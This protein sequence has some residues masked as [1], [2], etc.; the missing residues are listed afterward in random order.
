MGNRASRLS[1]FLA[2]VMLTGIAARTVADSPD[3]FAGEAAALAVQS[4]LSVYGLRMTSNSVAQIPAPE[5]KTVWIRGLESVA[6]GQA[7]LP[8]G[9]K[10]VAAVI[11]EQDGVLQGIEVLWARL[12]PGGLGLAGLEIDCVT[13]ARPDK[14]LKL[15]M[16]PHGL[17]GGKPSA[18]FVG[19]DRTTGEEYF[20]A[21]ATPNEAG[22][23]TS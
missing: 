8:D 9:K 11:V 2:A 14:S 1:I 19:T 17:D 13:A 4:D 18:E 20:H 16:R 6:G 15:I 10:P 7:Q 22:D 23:L 5:G 21:T 3:P 12:G